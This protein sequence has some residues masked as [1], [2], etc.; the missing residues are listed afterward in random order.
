VVGIEPDF[1]HLKYT[2]WLT[3]AVIVLLTFLSSACYC[4]G[5]EYISMEGTPYD[6]SKSTGR[7]WVR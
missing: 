2:L 3:S 7:S 5:E 1:E 6:R 4:S